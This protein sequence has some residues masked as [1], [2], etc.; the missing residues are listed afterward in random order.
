VPALRGSTPAPLRDALDAL[1]WSSA[2]EDAC[3]MEAARES[4]DPAACDGL[5]LTR[6]RGPCRD[7]VAVA[8]GRPEACSLDGEL[9]DPFCVALASRRPALC[10]AVPLG[11][12]AACEA[13]LGT[14]A[15]PGPDEDRCGRSDVPDGPAC[16]ALAGTFAALVPSERVEGGRTELAVRLRTVRSVPLGSGR[17]VGE[18]EE[19]DLGDRELGA[20][21]RWDGCE[22]IVR[23]GEDDASSPR[24]P[25]YFV[26]VRW[27]G[28]VP[29]R[30]Q[31]GEGARVEVERDS[32][33]EASAGG[34]VG[35]D[36]RVDITRLEP[37]L[38]GRLDLTVR[39]ALTRSP[40]QVEL[41]LAV[42]TVLRDVIGAP[43]VS[44][45]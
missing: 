42:E 14:R 20:T 15:R 31:A 21:L 39:G 12:R 33:G 16:R 45:E 4:G 41:E 40:G 24:R 29:A 13:L 22:R 7:R 32:F 23:V 5:S 30:V 26:E 27:R 35:G 17:S 28:P 9:H 6:L 19:D 37:E 11:R 43:G 8:A 34:F 1:G 18:P 25:R 3:A 36:A 2:Y 10:R 44:C 38:G